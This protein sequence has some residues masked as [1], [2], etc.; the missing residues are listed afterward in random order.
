MKS[1][2]KGETGMAKEE[3]MSRWKKVQER[4]LSFWE[5]IWRKGKVYPDM[6]LNR[7]RVCLKL[8]PRMRS[9]RV[10]DVGSG[11]NSGILPFVSECD[12]KVA[13]DPLLRH[14]KEATKESCVAGMGEKLPF[15]D[16]TFDIVFSINCIDHSRVP[17]LLL[18]EINRVLKEG[19][20]SDTAVARM[21]THEKDNPKLVWQ[22]A[23]FQ[24]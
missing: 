3:E 9:P 1:F 16:E 20:F 17:S 12:F 15:R 22:I 18:K 2:R 13:I 14:I 6:S 8:M 24:N 19:G 21:L 7:F 4:E 10:L 23:T 5:S 11:P